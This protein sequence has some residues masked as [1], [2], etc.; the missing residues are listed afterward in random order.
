MNVLAIESA[1]IIP[2]G[3]HGVLKILVS[4][5]GSERGYAP[6]PNPDVTRVLGW[7]PGPVHGLEHR[8]D[9][10][11]TRVCETRLGHNP[12]LAAIKHLNRLE[13]VLARAELAQ[14]GTPEGIMLDLDGNVVAGSMSNL[15]LIRSASLVTADLGC[16]GVAGIVR[17]IVLERAGEWNLKPEI[18]K[19]ALQDV[20]R[21]DELFFSNSIIGI[22]PVRGMAGHRFPG[23]ERGRRIMADLAAQGQ[24]RIS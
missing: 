15:F 12:R 7:F 18:R 19:V 17:E 20:Q 6:P 14:S 24:V 13:Q 1:G 11:E 5:G 10:I 16:C 23:I 9:G 22:W 2:P 4:R 3:G 8:R 21:A